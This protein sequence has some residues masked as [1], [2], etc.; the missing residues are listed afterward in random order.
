MTAAQR[1]HRAR[2]LDPTADPAAS[3]VTGAAE[4]AAEDASQLTLF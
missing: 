4:P 3:T 1:R 2:P